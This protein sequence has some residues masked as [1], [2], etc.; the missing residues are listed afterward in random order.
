MG[1]RACSVLR[2]FFS[3]SI[4]LDDKEYEKKR[5]KKKENTVHY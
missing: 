1:I 2:L 5:K 4:K 3:S